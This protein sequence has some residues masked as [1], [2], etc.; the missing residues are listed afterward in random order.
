MLSVPY[1]ETSALD[2]TNVSK[3]VD[4]LLDLVMKRIEAS[5]TKSRIHKACVDDK[6][7]VKLDNKQKQ[8]K[9]CAC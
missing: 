8:E 5:V 1:I 3:A 6:N 7:T 4:M 2:G 9:K